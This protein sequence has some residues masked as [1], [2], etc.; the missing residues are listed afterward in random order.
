MNLEILM[1]IIT[2]Y[3]LVGKILLVMGTSRAFFKVFHTFIKSFIQLTPSQK[4]DEAMNK[5]EDGKIFKAIQWLLDFAFS[6]KVK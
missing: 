3:P 4:D 5:F 1:N 6:I 2:Q